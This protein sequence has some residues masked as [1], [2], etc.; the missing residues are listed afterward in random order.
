M[1]TND[2]HMSNVIQQKTKNNFMGKESKI[3]S[4]QGHCDINGG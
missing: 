1:K 2:D 4:E 3:T